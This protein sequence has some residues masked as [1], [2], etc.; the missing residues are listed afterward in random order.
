M[1]NISRVY[2]AA[3]DGIGIAATLEMNAMFHVCGISCAQGQIENDL[4]DI[5]PDFMILDGAFAARDPLALLSWMRLNMPAPPRVLYLMRGDERWGKEALSLGADAVISWPND[6]EIFLS[7]CSETAQ[8]A[9]PKLSAVWQKTREKVAE[10]LL[11]RLQV[12]AGL[13]GRGYIHAA[14]SDG[15]CSPWLIQSFS[16][17]L[18]PWLAGKFSST[19]QA[20]ERAIRVAIENTWLNG[21]LNAIQQLFGF[22]VDA[23]KGKPTNAEFLSMLAAHAHRQM[24]RIMAENAN[25]TD[26][27][28]KE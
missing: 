17:R 18:Y 22:S 4:M 10:R 11:D 13:K 1:L 16:H 9:C 27:S 6:D 3:A 14:I 20:V 26:H 24:L 19:P 25:K 21:D 23:D 12:P 8:S 28:R 15:A 7:L 2:V 5:C